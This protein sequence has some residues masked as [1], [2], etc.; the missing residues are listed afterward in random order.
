M[1][2]SGGRGQPRRGCAV[3]A[4][5]A[6]PMGV[7]AQQGEGVPVLHGLEC[8]L[9]GRTAHK[10]GNTKGFP[11]LANQP[12]SFGWEQAHRHVSK[13]LRHLLPQI[14]ARCARKSKSLFPPA[15][16]LPQRVS[17][18]DA[19]PGG[20]RAM[21]APTRY[22][23]SIWR[24]EVVAPYGVAVT[25]LPVAFGRWA[26]ESLALR[27]LRAQRAL[28]GKWVIDKR[29][30]TDLV[31]SLLPAVRPRRPRIRSYESAPVNFASAAQNGPPGRRPLRIVPKSQ[32][33][34][35]QL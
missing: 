13:E 22:G 6:R 18:T 32:A 31:S 28:K 7:L 21:R 34:N 14:R 4:R 16:R 15:A 35:T 11:L 10:K 19:T 27:T 26:A 1:P 8:G 5:S 12:H 2:A 9:R 33:A 30:E 23:R 17:G 24:A 3:G 25:P 20:G 29:E